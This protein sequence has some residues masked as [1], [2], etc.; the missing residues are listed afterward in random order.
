MEKKKYYLVSA[1]A[2]PEVFI[3]VAEAKRMLQVGE[4]DTVGEAARLVGISRSA[5]YKYKDAVQPFQNMRAGHIITFYALLKDI[6]GVL[7]NYLSI[8]A[9]SGANILTINQTIPTNGCAGVTISADIETDDVP[10]WSGTI[11]A[12]PMSS[13]GESVEVTFLESRDTVL[14]AIYG[15]DNVTTSAGTTTVRHNTKFNGSH[16]F[17]FDA[18]VSDTK[19]KRIVIPNGVIVERDDVEM[20]NS[21]LTG[22][23]PT[24]KCLPST[25]FEGDLMREYIYDTTYT[26]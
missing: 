13:Y 17:I 6:P 2:L 10:D 19:V 12:S 20:N 24:I 16:L 3:K 18:V 8:F 11:V 4:A 1:E 15:E 21:D 7:S 23:K 5:F 14:K 9:G 26:A 22:Y 25:F